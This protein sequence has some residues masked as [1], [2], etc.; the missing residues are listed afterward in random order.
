MQ[1]LLLKAE[2]RD[3]I[4]VAVMM[5]HRI[6]VIVTDVGI[7]AEVIVTT[8]KKAVAADIRNVHLEIN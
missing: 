4:V 7:M 8:V 1:E 6:M 3:V 2:K 5:K